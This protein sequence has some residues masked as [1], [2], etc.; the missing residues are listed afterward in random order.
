MQVLVTPDTQTESCICR[1]TFLTKA[2]LKDLSSICMQ[3]KGSKTLAILFYR[4]GIVR[5]DEVC[6]GTA[7]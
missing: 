6:E 5:L 7:S 4:Q 2:S 1:E 3:H